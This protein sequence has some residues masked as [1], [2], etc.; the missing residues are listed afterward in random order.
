MTGNI[1]LHQHGGGNMKKMTLAVILFAIL[2]C[3]E[4]Y[5]ISFSKF[6][7]INDNF[8]YYMDHIYEKNSKCGE[9]IIDEDK[10]EIDLSY[11]SNAYTYDIKTREGMPYMFFGGKEYMVLGR[12]EFMFLYEKDKPEV[13]FEGQIADVGSFFI[14][15][16]KNRNTVS[17]TSF[18]TE[19]KK[20]YRPENI[21]I[22]A[23]DCPWV[24]GVK[25]YGIG[26]RIK[27]KA[28]Q[29]P[30]WGF[31][32]SIGYV[33]YEKPYLYK[34]NS[35]PKIIRLYF[36]D[37]D[38]SQVYELV[39]TPNPQILQFPF[40][41]TYKEKYKGSIEMEILDVYKGESWDDTCINFIKLLDSKPHEY[42]RDVVL[43]SEK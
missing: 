33:S 17:A 11:F 23:S 29:E 13:F 28:G 43:P 4:L 15:P 37:A 21:F 34:K 39:D 31:L 25:G 3:K 9:L 42:E 14:D 24:E 10:K 32:I 8:I 16:D 26:E 38:K 7:N 40:M 35:R 6:F 18:L 22:N 27:V 20:E 19:G 12:K 36:V 41:E 2:F 5:A 30:I 1:I